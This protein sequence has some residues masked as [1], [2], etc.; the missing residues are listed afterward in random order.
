MPKFNKGDK[1]VRTNGS[2]FGC[3]ERDIVTVVS[4]NDRQLSLEEHLDFT[5][6]PDYFELLVEEETLPEVPDSTRYECDM[7]PGR[8]FICLMKKRDS[9]VIKA[10]EED[11][12]SS[13]VLS[14]ETAL[15]MAS[16]LRRMAMKIKREQ[17]GSE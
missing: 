17:E 5:Y 2:A 11:E 12:F 13:V 8:D 7:Y 4:C 6:D 10:E 14:V 16:D 15:A 9:V 3:K 1:V